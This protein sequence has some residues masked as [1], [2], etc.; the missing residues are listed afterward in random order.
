MLCVHVAHICFG[1]SGVSLLGYVEVSS[2][3]DANGI[4]LG[5]PRFVYLMNDIIDTYDLTLSYRALNV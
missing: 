5:S 4:G 3:K 1:V 2:Y